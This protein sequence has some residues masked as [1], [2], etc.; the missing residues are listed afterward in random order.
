MD[1]RDFLKIL[2]ASATASYVDY[3]KLLWIPSPHIVVP[4]ISLNSYQVCS[5]WE[6][7]VDGKRLVQLFE[8][9]DLFYS[10]L[11]ERTK[12]YELNPPDLL[13]VMRVP[14]S[15]SGDKK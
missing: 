2:L 7:L 11:A 10:M 8:K 1:R 3:E 15:W 14:L 13:K 4:D 12:P 9:D 5:I 6:K